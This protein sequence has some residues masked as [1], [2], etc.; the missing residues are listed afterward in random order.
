MIKHLAFFSRRAGLLLLIGIGFVVLFFSSLSSVAADEGTHLVFD[1]PV[2]DLPSTSV[3]VAVRVEN[4]T[5]LYGLQLEVHFDPAVVTVESIVPG[6]FL[7]ADFVLKDIDGD[8]GW[9]SLAYTQ[10]A[11]APERNGSGAVAVLTLKRTGCAGS[12]PLKL[13]NVILSDI[14]GQAIS[15]TLGT[16]ETSSGTAPLNRQISGSIFHDLNEDGLPS[17]Q[18]P[19]LA[20]WPIFLQR[21]A[22]DPIGPEYAVVSKAGGAFQF[23][24]LACGRYRLWSQNGETRVLT[25]TVTLPATVD[26]ELPALPLTGTLDYPA[27]RLFLPVLTR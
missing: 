9:A 3:T 27:S 10:L 1:P 8:A 18:E 7:S 16:G 19:S 4:V 25:Q 2:L 20:G 21:Q 23:D 13:M 17:V 6:D 15:H 24:D 11:P 12:S 14:N 26:V 5:N 22:V